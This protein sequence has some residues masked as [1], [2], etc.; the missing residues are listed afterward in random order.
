[1]KKNLISCEKT[2]TISI[3]FIALLIMFSTQMR[4]QTDTVQTNVPALKDVY[5]NDFYTG[6]ILSY[7]HIGFPDDPYVPGQSAVVE[8]N[9]GYLIQFHMNSMSPGNN[10]KPVYTVDIA[11]SAAAYTAASAADKDSVDIHPIVKFN[12]DLIAQLEWA[13][14]QEFTFRGHTLVWH[15]QTPAELFRSG[16]TSGG[17]RLGK[18]KMIERM[19]NYIKEVIRLL[20]EGWPGLL[21]AIDV[22]NEAVNDDGSDRT[23]SEWYITFGDTSYLMTAFKLTRKHTIAYG[24]TQIKLYYNDYNAHLPS[25]AD[26]IVRICTPIFQAGYLDGIGMQDHDSNSSPTAAQWIATYNKF[27][28][29]CTEMAVTELDVTTGSANPSAGVLATQ[30]NQYGQLFKCFVE[31]SYFS[32]R[33][34]IINVTKDGL[35]DQYTFKTNQASSLWDINNQCKPAFY[36]VV[37]VGNHYN[38][39]DSLTAYADTLNESDYTTDSWSVFATALTAAHN[40]MDQNYSASLSAADALGTAKVN[41]EAAIDGLVKIA[42]A[43]AIHQGNKVEDFALGQNYPNPFNPIT[44]IEFSLPENCTVHLDVYDVLG[45]RVSDLAGGN[46]RAGNYKINFNA[47]NLVSGV[48]F[49]KLAAGKYT[50]VKKLMLMK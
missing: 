43:I 47:S 27:E 24:E 15:N 48:Y 11:A 17:T 49:Y 33:G 37:D 13:W 41:L 16:Y 2:N 35:N 40:A 50:D 19:D 22:V 31:R 4:A 1:M 20:H 29:I 12:G 30:A 32:G 8:P 18:A 21:S 42:D 5:A 7:K 10:M 45:R 34:K 44:S 23:T 46:Y 6:C 3:I 36:A 38:A 26:G 28:P 25:K 14:R 39:L 9:G